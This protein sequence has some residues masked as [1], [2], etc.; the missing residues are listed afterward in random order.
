MKMTEQH[1]FKGYWW[2]PDKPEDKVAGV[3]TYS[4]GERILLELI[5]GFESEEVTIAGFLDKENNKV[6]LIHGV[7]SNA[8]EIS[9]VSCY[10]SFSY[11]YSSGFPIMH[12]STRMAIYGKHINSLGEVCDYSAHVRFPELSYWLHHLQYIRFYIMRQKAMNWNPAH[13]ILNTLIRIQNLSAL[14]T[15]ITVS[16]FLSK[17]GLDIKLTT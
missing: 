10:R 6:A 11:N 17:K 3:L 2:L 4:P 7:D 13:F 1:V 16:S 9:L 15:V 14:W 12:Y 8:M 5:G